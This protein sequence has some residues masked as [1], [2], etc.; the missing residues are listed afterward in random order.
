MQVVLLVL[1][2]LLALINHEIQVRRNCDHVWEDL[3][4]SGKMQCQECGLCKDRYD[5]TH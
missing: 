5:D 4:N 3:D 1:I 2:L